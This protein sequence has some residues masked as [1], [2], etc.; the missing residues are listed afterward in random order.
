MGFFNIIDKLK[1]WLLLLF[2][3]LCFIIS[4]NISELWIFYETIN[5]FIQISKGRIRNRINLV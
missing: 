4:I 2:L 5:K 3:F 1:L